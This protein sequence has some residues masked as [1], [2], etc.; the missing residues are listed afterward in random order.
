VSK[1]VRFIEAAVGAAAGYSQARR[2]R[3]PVFLAG[4]AFMAV[5]M[6]LMLTALGFGLATVYLALLCLG[7]VWACL[8]TGVAA[9]TAGALLLIIGQRL[10]RAA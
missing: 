1:V 7:A 10:M 5:A 2:K 4:G 9:L 3:S 8:L 6:L